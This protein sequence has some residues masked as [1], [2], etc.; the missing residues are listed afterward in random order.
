MKIFGYW[1]A[2]IL[3]AVLTHLFY[4]Q[5]YPINFRAPV[6]L[7]L[8]AINLAQGIWI[9]ILN[10]FEWRKVLLVICIFLAGQWW[11]FMWSA[12]F[13]VWGTRGFAP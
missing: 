3:I 13:I 8:A 11:F 2:F 5:N 9:L 10:R 1:F 6:L 4:C 12:I 7:I